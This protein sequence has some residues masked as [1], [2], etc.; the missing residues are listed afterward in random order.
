MDFK[1]PQCIEAKDYDGVAEII[2]ELEKMSDSEE[3]V[4]E[5]EEDEEE[6]EEVEDSDD[7]SDSFDSA[8]EE[9]CLWGEDSVVDQIESGSDKEWEPFPKRS[10]S[11]TTT[12]TASQQSPSPMRRTST[13]TPTKKNKKAQ[14]RSSSPRTPR[15][16]VNGASR[17]LEL[18]EEERWNDITDEDKQPSL[19]R[20]HPKRPPG[21]Q[22][23]PGKTYSPL[24]LFQL[25]FSSSVV[26]TLVDNTNKFGKISAAGGKKLKW[27]PVTVKEFYAFIGLVV[28]MGLVKV[29]SIMDLWSKKQLYQFQFP[30]MVMSS[31]RFTAISSNLH[32]SD[33]EED[34]ENM[35]KKGTPD[36]DRLFKIKPLYTDILSAC[37][38]F[39]QPR[40]ELS[41]DE[42]MVASKA[43]TG[44]K[45]YMKAKPT[46]WGFK[47]F[48]LADSASGY[49][50]NFFVYEGKS[51]FASGKGLSYDTVK[52]LLDYSLLGHGYM[53][54]M[55]NFYTSPTLLS[56][57]LQENTLACGT[58][59]T[60][61][62]GLSLPKNNEL[63]KRAERGD[64]RWYR[65]GKL[66]Y[67]KWMDTREVTMCS[68]MHKAYK[69]DTVKRKVKSKEGVWDITTVPIPAAVKDYNKHMGG[70]DLSDA[71]IGYYHVLHKSRK[72]YKT[73]FFHFIDI[74]IVNSFILHQQLADV[75]GQATLT[76]KAFREALVMELTK[77][78]RKS[79]DVSGPKGQSKEEKP[80]RTSSPSKRTAQDE[81]CMP[82]FYGTDA[83]AGRKKCEHCKKD[84]RQTKTPVFCAK[85]GVPLCL[86]PARNCFKLWHEDL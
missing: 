77:T 52:T 75:T 53:V 8:I 83:T 49:T 76:Q 56:D 78:V 72:W 62:L 48:I 79:K 25:F 32:L 37:H 9:A 24:Q 41:I 26:Q 16:Q 65:Q 18:G 51:P 29:K 15:K 11:V 59:R 85:C 45:Q 20:F 44:L 66:L 58:L 47:L 28:Y 4:E 74:A 68:T 86:V 3:V 7:S 1:T 54:Y 33:P 19:F 73:F 84:G 22:L 42:R 63:P 39:F 57:L 21:P 13:L 40:R 36:Y 23:L 38:S 50:W 17:V 69:G 5:E 81:M 34:A 10:R 82:A 70:V 46:K 2:V 61:Q 80:T 14:G 64:I 60:N 71:L 35:K 43:R 6:E 31:K 27:T 55:D 67:V 30:S 12:P